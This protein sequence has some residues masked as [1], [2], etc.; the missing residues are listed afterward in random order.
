MKQGC[1]L[2]ALMLCA[3]ISLSCVDKD[4]LENRLDSLTLKIAD[5][6]EWVASSNDNAIAIRKFLS[7]DDILIVGYEKTAYGYTLELSDGTSVRVSFGAQAPTRIPII[8]IDAD[9]RWTL[10]WDGET[11]QVIEGTSNTKDNDGN[12]PQIRVNEDGCW[13]FSLDGGVTWRP[14]TDAS[15]KPVS[16]IDGASV[17]GISSFFRNVVYDAD[18]GKMRFTLQ[19]GRTV[20]VNIVDGFYL[21]I[22][23]YKPGR[24][25]HLEE[26][27][28]YEVE[29]SDIAQAIVMAPEGWTVILSEEELS[30]TAPATGAEGSEAQIGLLLVSSKGYIRRT[31]LAY[32]LSTAPNIGK[33]GLKTW[34]DFFEGNE[35]NHLVDFSYAGYEHG[36][37]APPDALDLGWTVYDVTDYGAIPSDGLSDRDAVL[38]AYQAAIGAG[39]VHNPE[40][41]AVLYFPEGEY[42]LHTS[43]DNKDGKSE[44]LLMRAGYFAIK[45]AGKDKTTL[46]MQDPNLPASEALYSSPVMLELKHN[47]GLADLTTVTADADKGSFSVTVASSAGIMPGDWVCLWVANNDAAFV[48]DELKPYA[49]TSSMTNIVQTGVQVIDYHQVAS[50]SENVVTFVEPIMHKVEA[51][52]NWSL[53]KYPHYNMVGVEDLTFKGNAKADFVHHGSWEDDGAYKPLAMTRLTNAWLRRVRFTSVSEACTITNS[54]NVSAYAIEIDGNRGHAAIRSQQSSR[55]FIGK[56][57]DHTDGPLVSNGAHMQNTGQY[58]AVGVSKPS[59]G[60]VLWRNTWGDDSCFEAH[61]TQPRATLVD[62]CEGGWMQFRQGGDEAQV[63]NH[64]QDLVIWNFCSTTPFTGMWD[65]WKSA[66]LWWKFLPPV[67]VGFHGAECEFVASQT[68]VDEA[69]GTLAEPESLYEAQLR[70]RLG[71]V[72]AWLNSIK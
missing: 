59:M 36:E 39:A 19:D 37:S 42:I 28:L 23:G 13:E 1:K 29:T 65:W 47:S 33:T 68:L 4:R 18:A 58:H 3:A 57:Y 26:T 51:R 20:D 71:V 24:T 11:F 16:A 63:P 8:G 5:L 22:H 45:G 17:A 52:W 15:G 41:R 61:A 21:R 40:A 10:S 35:D 64:M 46:V 38:R 70:K 67:I 7:G 27:L 62:C 50:V 43:A 12:T 66:S 30:V 14:V 25:I 49:A 55:V 69:H 56:V 44:S 2:I 32:V 9:G 53:K 72:P 6:E 31:G 60:T 48:A 34:D 54:A